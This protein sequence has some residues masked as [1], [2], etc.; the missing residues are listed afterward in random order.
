MDEGMAGKERGQWVWCGQVSGPAKTH[1]WSKLVKVTQCPSRASLF[2]LSF[3][4]LS[5]M[6]SFFVLFHYPVAQ[7][8]FF[9]STEESFH[10]HLQYLP[11]YVYPFPPLFHC[12]VFHFL[13]PPQQIT[14]NFSTV[15]FSFLPFLI[16]SH[17]HLHRSIS[18][19]LFPSACFLS[20]PSQ[21]HP[22]IS[23]SYPPLLRWTL[24]FTTAFSFLHYSILTF[25]L[26]HSILS[27]L[28]SFTSCILS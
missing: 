28:I 13:Y 18:S 7:V 21:F 1:T 17:C 15:S 23:L 14:P 6:H 10:F 20:S 27:V 4:I 19:F 11:F 22:H 5:F 2:T 25:T 16:T 8:T 24:P 9:P 26:H 12:L 3:I